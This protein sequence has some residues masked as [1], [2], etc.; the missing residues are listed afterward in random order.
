MKSFKISLFVI[1]VFLWVNIQSAFAD[2]DLIPTSISLQGVE[3]VPASNLIGGTVSWPVYVLNS[4]KSA[5]FIPKII[6]NT[7]NQGTFSTDK[8][9]KNEVRISD[10]SFDSNGNQ[11]YR[12]EWVDQNTILAPG[13]SAQSEVD[14]NIWSPGIYS[15]QVCVDQEK[16][17]YPSGGYTIGSMEGTLTSIENNCSEWTNI[18]IRDSS[19]T[20]N[21][22]WNLTPYLYPSTKTAI[23]EAHD[24][25]G[26]NGIGSEYGFCVGTSPNPTECK[27]TNPPENGIFSDSWVL[28]SSTKYYFRAYLK[29]TPPTDTRLATVIAYSDDAAFRMS[30]QST[31]SDLVI[32]DPISVDQSGKPTN[33]PFIN[34]GFIKATVTNKGSGSTLFP[35]HISVPSRNIPKESPIITMQSNYGGQVPVDST[36]SAGSSREVIIPL[37]LECGYSFFKVCVDDDTGNSKFSRRYGLSYYIAETNEVNNC[38]PGDWENN[39]VEVTCPQPEKIVLPDLIVSSSVTPTSA[40]VDVP[41]VYSA[42]IKNKGES[43][44]GASFANFFQSATD[45]TD[46][47]NPIGVKDYDAVSTMNTLISNA[48]AVTTSKSITFP[49]EGTYY[50]RACADKSSS[51]DMGDIKESDE[52]HNCSAWTPVIVSATGFIDLIVFSEVTPS[53]AVL[54][55]STTF[56]ATIK[57]I[58]NISTGKDFNNFFQIA[59]NPNDVTTIIDKTFSGMTKLAANGVGVAKVNHKFETIGRYYIRVCADK[60]SRGDTGLIDESDEDH[61]CSSEW[62]SITVADASTL[63]LDF[64]AVNYGKKLPCFSDPK[65]CADE[66]DP[67]YAKA[68]CP[69]ELPKFIDAKTGLCTDPSED[70][71]PGTCF[72][73]KING[74]ETD[75]D[76]GGRCLPEKKCKKVFN[77]FEF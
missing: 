76:C 62:S 54:N 15:I 71:D 46:L 37:N 59:T 5:E 19:Q 7:K 20:T 49:K 8:G 50:I 34:H 47:M 72:D 48:E 56:S 51:G 52:D 60:S 57:N 25:R 73:G 3:L 23:L 53:S 18:D 26:D 31:S 36:L 38:S 27:A 9:F 22:F 41:T 30:A 74:N 69:C 44:T 10:L 35:F 13:A 17:T 29:R 66:A 32:S 63:C 28:N 77:W 68:P 21:V 1:F 75:T 24:R 40:V 16:F 70:E 64:D 14:S 12:S 6:F 11:N 39:K 61:N 45:V 58:G 33:G 67:N 43:T 42:T 2:V 55:T 65:L 4:S